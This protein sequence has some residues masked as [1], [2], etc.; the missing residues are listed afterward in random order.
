MKELLRDIGVEAT[1]ENIK[2]ID[3][4]LHEMLSVDYPNC[5]ATWKM[6]RKK[7]QIDD[8]GFKERLNDLVQ[9]RL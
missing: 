5:A 6:L 9:I 2:M 3:E 8:E 7:L 4:I 1:K